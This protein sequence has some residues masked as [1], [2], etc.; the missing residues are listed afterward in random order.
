[1]CQQISK[2]FIIQNRCLQLYFFTTRI[3][4]LYVLC[5]KNYTK[6][7]QLLFFFHETIYKVVMV[8]RMNIYSTGSIIVNNTLLISQLR[9]NKQ[10]TKTEGK[11]YIRYHRVKWTPCGLVVGW[12][13]VK[14]FCFGFFFSMPRHLKHI[15]I[16]S[17]IP[18]KVILILCLGS[19]F[20]FLDIIKTV[21]NDIFASIQFMQSDTLNTKFCIGIKNFCIIGHIKENPKQLQCNNINHIEPYQANLKKVFLENL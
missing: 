6:A 7:S 14:F 11:L 19:H 12:P 4:V 2:R 17:G 20:G 1:M 10:K 3:K 15:L 21:I 18:W 16:K 8:K 13:L 9:S 5:Y